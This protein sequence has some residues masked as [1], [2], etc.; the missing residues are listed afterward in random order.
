[1]KKRIL[2]VE[3][4]RIIAE[5]ITRILRSFEYDIAGVVPSGEEALAAANAL[6]PDLVLMDIMLSTEMSGVEAAYKIH[7][8]F[9]I[10]ITFLT[11]YA[12]DG[13]ISRATMADPFGYV[14]KPF[15]ERELHATIQMAFYKDNLN[16]ALRKSEKKYR[17]LIESMTEGIAVMDDTQK[18]TFVNSACADIFGLEQESLLSRN[19]SE[20][21]SV[22]ENVRLQEQIRNRK[23]GA[24]DKYSLRINRDDGESRNLLIAANPMEENGRFTGSFG[25][26]SDIT[27]QIQAEEKLHQTQFRLATVFDN[28]PDIVLFEKN[29][30]E[31]FI[32]DNIE[33]LLGW[34]PKDFTENKSFFMSLVHSEDIEVTRKKFIKWYHHSRDEILTLWYR[35]R[36]TDGTYIWIESRLVEITPENKESYIAGVLINISPLKEVE[37]ALRK[38][39]ALYR[40]V[41]EDQN[42]FITRFLPD[43]TFTFVNGA[44][45]RHR[46][47]PI[48]KLIGINW[49]KECSE[50]EQK[51]I[52][53]RLEQLTETNPVITQTFLKEYL[54]GTKYWTEW[55]Y[56][57]IFNENKQLTEIQSIGNDITD[58]MVAEEEKEKIRNQLNQSQKMEVVGR[59][60]GGI[61]HD[62]NNLLTAINGYSDILKSKIPKDDPL[63][64]YVDVISNTGQKAAQLTK[65]LLGFS[66]KQIVDP[67]VLNINKV[68]SE[69]KKM[70][71]QLIGNNIEYNVNL[72][73]NINK[74]KADPGQMEQVLVNL[75]VNA[76]DA[77][78]DNGTIDV[79]TENLTYQ[80]D[81]VTPNTTI[82]EGKYIA[83]NVRDNG[84]GIKDEN[85]EKI[86]EPFY[87]TKEPGK[88]TGLG[89]STVFGIVR[90]N[91][92]YIL[93]NSEFGKFSEF[94]IIFPISQETEEPEKIIL[95]G[96]ENLPTGSETI[97]L[98]EDESNIRLFITE[99][100]S[101]FGY[102]ILSAANGEE[103][104]NIANSNSGIDLLLT[105]VRMP[106]IN[107]FE[108][109]EKL[110]E[111]HPNVKIIFVS[112]YAE[113]KM[114][115]DIFDRSD[116]AFLQ[117]P[118]SVPDLITLVRDTLE[119]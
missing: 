85:I 110:K 90:Q 95:T 47:I 117:K 58:K 76:R 84:E 29:K 86:F 9:N 73:D 21:L 72:S 105:D 36:K 34:A 8:E 116:S 97:L 1:V 13:T 101:E 19:F 98:A 30:N 118:F 10:P 67:K 52:N 46:N 70:L 53:E 100:L 50:T 11:A 49:I 24:S 71:G 80:E 96:E 35:I 107:G 4:E 64:E 65:Q 75:I 61:A 109:A 108:L 99:V 63:R 79:S 17:T 22:N 44:Y 59:L 88:G 12:D 20:F 16:K 87:T 113:D 42:E 89:L 94:R 91:H 62:F 119:L 78:A 48:E 25:I 81:Y 28:V 103:A 7:D 104:L 32:S 5:D 37:E 31:Q 26:L 111:T 92:G 39:R 51:A 15:E 41:V 23:A 57:A 83:F 93:V 106:I 45:S 43:G 56:R 14:L 3:D 2:I 27:K 60:A 68:I 77:V 69:M 6:K 74:F 115:N 102:N 82:P 66:R 112:G 18:F 114:K 54:D 33:N 38:S 55:K 40:T